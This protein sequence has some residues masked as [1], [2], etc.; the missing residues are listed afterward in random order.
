MVAWQCSQLHA[1]AK[2]LIQQSQ[3][4]NGNNKTIDCVGN[5]MVESSGVFN[6]NVEGLHTQVL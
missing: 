1:K 4:Q 2:N 5:F 3:S 6:A